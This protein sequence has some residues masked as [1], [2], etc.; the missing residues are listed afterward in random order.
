MDGRIPG[1]LVRCTGFFLFARSLLT[2]HLA[3]QLDGLVSTGQL[4]RTL[5]QYSSLERPPRSFDTGLTGFEEDR[6]C[7]IIVCNTLKLAAPLKLF[8]P[9]VTSAWKR[10][11]IGR[12]EG[13]ESTLDLPYTDACFGHSFVWVPWHVCWLRFL[14]NTVRGCWILFIVKQRCAEEHTRSRIREGHLSRRCVAI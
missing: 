10:S 12:V 8:S 4:L 1:Q 7:A 6:N 3:C 13:L 5:A 11:W 2:L 9:S 14:G